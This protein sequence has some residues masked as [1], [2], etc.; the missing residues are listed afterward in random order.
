MEAAVATFVRTGFS[1]SRGGEHDEV[2]GAMT[3][4]RANVETKSLE[5]GSPHFEVGARA[6]KSSREINSSCSINFKLRGICWYL[7][8]IAALQP[9]AES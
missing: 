1:V 8:A 3:D 2:D 6:W 5:S 7:F 4:D 9:L